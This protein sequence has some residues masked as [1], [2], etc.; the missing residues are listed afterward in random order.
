MNPRR[1]K[2]ANGVILVNRKG[3]D[4]VHFAEMGAGRQL[5]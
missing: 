5:R 3:S 1:G 2:G 4:A